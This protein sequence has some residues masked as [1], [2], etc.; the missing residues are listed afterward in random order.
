ML[1]GLMIAQHVFKCLCSLGQ[2]PPEKKFMNI[3]MREPDI[4]QMYLH[5]EESP[6]RHN[7]IMHI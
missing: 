5:P 1:F 2:L 7:V 6:E 4:F 3:G